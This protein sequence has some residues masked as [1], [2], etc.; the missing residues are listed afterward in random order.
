MSAVLLALFITIVVA[1]FERQNNPLPDQP[2]WQCSRPIH[3]VGLPTG[4]IHIE[5]GLEW[6]PMT[7]D[8]YNALWKKGW[9]ESG[10]SISEFETPHPAARRETAGR[11]MK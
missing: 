2:C 8:E 7:F 1:L 3:W 9:E 10:I 5:T 4:W 6:W 11:G